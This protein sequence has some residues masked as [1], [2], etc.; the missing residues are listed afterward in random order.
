MAASAP[1]FGHSPNITWRRVEEQHVAR[2]PLFVPL[3]DTASDTRIGSGSFEAL[4]LFKQQS[5]QWDALHTGR[6]TTSKLA[7]FLGLFEPSAAAKLKVPKGLRGHSKAVS[8][9][10][11]LMIQTEQ[12][13]I[14]SRDKILGTVVKPGKA[15][16]QLQAILSN[17]GLLP[18]SEL[19]GA[20]AAALDAP[21]P[22]TPCGIW[23]RQQNDCNNNGHVGLEA[24]D[25]AI[26]CALAGQS[27]PE[28]G[29]PLYSFRPPHVL[30]SDNKHSH[31]VPPHG[32]ASSP[33]SAAAEHVYR[34]NSATEARL[35]WGS[36]QEATAV[37]VAVNAL[38]ADPLAEAE[39]H[40]HNRSAC[41]HDNA[42]FSAA[43]IDEPPKLRAPGVSLVPSQ[44]H[45]HSPLP[46]VVVAANDARYSAPILAPVATA[47]LKSGETSAVASPAS[48]AS[49][50]ILSPSSAAVAASL[51]PSRPLADLR[52]SRVYEIGLCP[53][54]AVPLPGDYAPAD[55][56]AVLSAGAT[57][58]LGGE[59]ATDAAT[60]DE[61]NGQ[62]D[63]SSESEPELSLLSL[64]P[65]VVVTKAAPVGVG[66]KGKKRKKKLQ[67]G[68]TKTLSSLTSTSVLARP[69]MNSPTSQHCTPNPHRFPPRPSLPLM[70]ASPDG[71]IIY[72]DGTVEV[73]EVKC[74]S[75]FADNALYAPNISSGSRSA[76]LNAAAAALNGTPASYDA[77]TGRFCVQDNGPQ[78]S[79][80]AW[81][82]PQLQLEILCAGAHCTGANLVSLSATR[83]AHVFY[84]PRDDAYLALMLRL[85]AALYQTHVQSRRAP[86]S[87]ANFGAAHPEYAHFLERTLAIA[88]A[89]ML[90]AA[91]PHEAVQRAPDN[92]LFFLD[93]AGAAGK[94][95]ASSSGNAS[96]KPR[97]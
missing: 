8:A 52:R 19:A 69:V 60:H 1:Q 78:T 72:G 64:T 37:L 61:E 38:I 22:C 82:I 74:H 11:H 35:L 67:R 51:L 77:R 84:V 3:P 24:L 90:R 93:G 76:A 66:S 85:V 12:H 10:Q 54:E 71:L 70:G 33:S 80:G 13:T 29:P 97:R 58:A 47:L 4:R 21:A 44:V 75:P 63:G 83:G 40:V 55:A 92:A 32:H 17:A 41:P 94:G 62:A 31:S 39:G 7:G 18:P 26:V 81:F 45:K 79:L 73:L 6:L 20:V 30:P 65:S 91:V 27:P 56:T 9:Y 23:S 46:P 68:R 42:S 49:R 43:S 87:S 88:N 96:L 15:D 59:K 86:P 50:S 95:S 34:A 14:A 89:A 25:P 5:W 36:A 53:L 16:A 57:A 2:H 48:F 28:V